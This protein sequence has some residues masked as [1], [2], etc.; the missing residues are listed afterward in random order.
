[1][2]TLNLKIITPERIVLEKQ[3]DRIVAKS[4]EGEL[5]ILPGHEPLVT[6]LAVDVVRFDSGKD[7]EFAAIMGGILEVREDEVTV[8][9]D[10]AELDAEIDEARAKAA[11]DRARAEKMEKKENLDVYVT[12]M[13]I[14]KAIARLRA[15][16]LRNRRRKPL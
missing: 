10:V 7:E 3:V 1:M 4:T 11:A 12:E 16:E 15:V 5:A 6:T 9:S 2:Q 14:S 8:L 13:A